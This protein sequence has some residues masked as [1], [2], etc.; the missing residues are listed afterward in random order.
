MTEHDILPPPQSPWGTMPRRGWLALACTVLAAAVRVCF[1]DD[2]LWIDE[3]Q[4]VDT[5]HKSWSS[6]LMTCGLADVH[7]PLYYLLLKVWSVFGDGDSA[8]R[9]LSLV[10]G[11]GT[12]GLFAWWV[13]GRFRLADVLLGTGFLLLSTFHIHYSVEIRG[14]ALFTFL[15]LSLIV[16]LEGWSERGRDRFPLAVVVLEVLVFLT[17]Y[18]AVFVLLAVNLFVFC[19]STLTRAQMRRWVMSQVAVVVAI[20]AWLPFT[21]VQMLDLPSGFTAHLAEGPPWDAILAAFGPSAAMSP[22][23][24]GATLG[25]VVVA[26][27][28]MGIF[29]RRTCVADGPEQADEGAAHPRGMMVVMGLAAIVLPL[30]PL[31]LPLSE[32]TFDILVARVPWAYGVVIVAT[33]GLWALYG[34][35][36]ARWAILR[37]PLVAWVVGASVLLIAL[38]Q[39]QRSTLSLRNVLFLL[40][41]VA[42]G[43]TKTVN[44][45]PKWPV[46]AAAVLVAS[47]SVA[48][49]D[50]GASRFESRA[51]F[52]GL[53]TTLGAQTPVTVL[54]ASKFD[55][56]AMDHYAR[57]DCRRAEEFLLEC[58]APSGRGAGL[59]VI[60][61]D[62][63]VAASKRLSAKHLIVLSRIHFRERDA[64]LA[65]LR[66]VHPRAEVM[67]VLPGRRGLQMLEVNPS[68]PHQ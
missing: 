10:L 66:Q 13:S 8:A 67:P 64:V 40:P 45:W 57:P 50:D 1:V 18:Y 36:P 26:L 55:L 23:W 5:A 14:Y 19:S 56:G 4:S 32:T 53:M 25:I 33:C 48:S 6:L 51:D 68:R 31:L 46:I 38:S 30:V 16:A 62:D 43:L 58:P 37:W 3:V 52:R 44:R 41:L 9:A 34:C 7:P 35:Q 11:S 59:R 28:L 61:V 60:G 49:L 47:F 42:Y 65:R 63:V 54:M 27:A 2:G 12:V 17:H 39:L 15:C 21:L 20:S 24:L 22:G 29:S